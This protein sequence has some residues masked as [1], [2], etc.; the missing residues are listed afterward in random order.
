MGMVATGRNRCAVVSE[1]EFAIDFG[2]SEN[3]EAVSIEARRQ[4]IGR[5]Q[6]NSRGKTCFS[7]NFQ[8]ALDDFQRSKHANRVSVGC[9]CLSAPPFASNLSK[10]C[11][12]KNARAAS[13]LHSF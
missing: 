1:M 13:V 12:T 9:H 11:N 7:T 8:Q 4:I 3:I 6:I 2:K 10:G 5:K